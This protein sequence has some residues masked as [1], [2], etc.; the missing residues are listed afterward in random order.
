M[1]IVTYGKIVNLCGF[2]DSVARVCVRQ[3]FVYC[4]V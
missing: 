4:N 2:F 1:S 3:S